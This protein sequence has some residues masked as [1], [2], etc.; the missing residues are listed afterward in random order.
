MHFHEEG[1]SMQSE[2]DLG[3]PSPVQKERPFDPQDKPDDLVD[4]LNPDARAPPLEDRV[5]AAEEPLQWEGKCRAAY[6]GGVRERKRD[7]I[8]REDAVYLYTERIAGFFYVAQDGGDDHDA[9]A[10]PKQD[11]ETTEIAV[12]A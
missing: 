6:H 4:G 7:D 11:E 1:K 8:L 3:S 2:E 5:T 10:Y 12:L 9:E